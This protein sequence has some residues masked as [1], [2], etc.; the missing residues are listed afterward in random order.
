MPKSLLV[1]AGS[2]LS[3]LAVTAWLWYSPG[4]GRVGGPDTS[5]VDASSEHAGNSE[6]TND[7]PFTLEP[8]GSTAQIL[9]STPPLTSDDEVDPLT[10]DPDLPFLDVSQVGRAPMNDADYESLVARLKL[11]PALL[12]QLIDEFRQEQNPERRALLARLIGEAGGSAVTQIASELIFSGDEAS[13]ELG[14]QLLRQ[15]QPGNAQA[16]DIASSLLATEVEPQV[17]VSTLSAL[18]SPGVVDE[19]SR[20]MLSDQVA[21]LASHSDAGVRG[22][23]L[24]ILSRWSTDGRDTPVLIN[25]LLDPEPR[26][27]ESAAYA[28]VGHEDDNVVV[29]ESLFTVVRNVDEQRATRSAAVMALR[30]F[31]LSDAQRDE[32]QGLERD[33]NTVNRFSKIIGPTVHPDVSCPQLT[34]SWLSPH[35]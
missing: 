16:R 33:L 18:A 25:A 13:R 27:R 1:A 11:D 14:L 19:T 10:N 26:V 8:A 3:A 31:T 9:A 24:D 20:A 15:V 7:S 17:L 22:V 5:G 21:L 28:L 30:S 23:S 32:L 6:A 4:S 29:V 12:Q 34:I 35:A 2:G